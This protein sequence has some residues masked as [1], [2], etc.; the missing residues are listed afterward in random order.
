MR[1]N[2]FYTT[3]LPL[4][5]PCRTFRTRGPR[6]RGGFTLLEMMTAVA[7]ILV[8]MAIGVIA[9]RAL[10]AS[11]S[12]K[13]TTATMASLQA[14]MA[15]VEAT[16]GRGRFEGVSGIYQPPPTPGEKPKIHMTPQ[17]SAEVP[18]PREVVPGTTDNSDRSRYGFAVLQTQR[19]IGQLMQVP[20]NK[21]NINQI[22]PKRLLGPAPAAWKDWNP[23]KVAVHDPATN[24]FTPS[25]P[26]PLDGWKNPLLFV[27]SGGL[28]VFIESSG[29]PA[30]AVTVTSPGNRPFWASAGPDGNF[31][32]GDD[33]LYSFS[34]Q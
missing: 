23:P 4:G 13:E 18:N 25:P 27:P 24:N 3:D 7:I 2:S 17:G 34:Q 14:M 21:T 32:T 28:E 5:P 19:V 16:T 6:R 22:S 26:V 12:R 8:L 29:D 10:D 9:F 31:A 20:R 33:N 15:E 11:A 1:R 30:K